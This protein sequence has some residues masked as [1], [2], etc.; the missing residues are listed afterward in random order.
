MSKNR[1]IGI[2]GENLACNF[3]LDKGYFILERNFRTKSGEIDII[4]RN[5]NIIIFVE[6]KTRSNNNYGFPYESVNYRKQQKIIRVAQNYINF[7]RLHDNQFRFDIIEVFF[8][9][10]NNKINHIRNAFWT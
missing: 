3:L 10:G 1:E 9:M 6:V 4:A 8:K 7:K 5:N 2:T